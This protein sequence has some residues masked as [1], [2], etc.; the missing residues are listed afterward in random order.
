[1]RLFFI[2]RKRNNNLSTLRHTS[3]TMPTHPADFGGQ[4]NHQYSNVYGYVGKC[5]GE[6][7]NLAFYDN[8]CVTLSRGFDCP[9]TP[10]M[11]VQNNSV[12]TQGGKGTSCKGKVARYP[13]DAQLSAM[14]ADVL[15]PFPMA[16]PPPGQ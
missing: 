2:M 9:T 6:G 4:W 5:W 16:A 13:S 12:Y 8:Q 10:S 1:M 14:A 7:N 3:F 11:T 15:A